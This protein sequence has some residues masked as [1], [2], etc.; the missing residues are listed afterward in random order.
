MQ[1]QDPM[2]VERYFRNSLLYNG[3]RFMNNHWH[4]SLQGQNDQGYLITAE[5]KK[6]DGTIVCVTPFRPAQW[7]EIRLAEGYQ[8]VW[9]LR[10]L[11]HEIWMLATTIKQS[12]P[13]HQG[14]P[15]HIVFDHNGLPNPD[16]T[17]LAAYRENFWK[18][19]ILQPLGLA[20]VKLRDHGT[21]HGWLVMTKG[22]EQIFTD[23]LQKRTEDPLHAI[24]N[25]YGLSPATRNL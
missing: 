7:N 11:V 14:G 21:S 5:I 4:L 25:H 18:Q 9:L 6:V 23:R 12:D 20:F 16:P 8:K 17:N 2:H 3:N 10:Q 15:L 22:E 1:Q 19:D 24:H 13:L